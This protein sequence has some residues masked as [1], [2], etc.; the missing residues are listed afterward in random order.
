MI[1]L[2]DYAE[3]FDRAGGSVNALLVEPARYAAITLRASAADRNTVTFG[4]VPL[5]Q[6]A[7]IA[8]QDEYD[9]GKLDRNVLGFP[10]SD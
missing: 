5:E 3:A 10:I 7:V 1:G 2:Y 6:Y 9:N 8:F 4:G